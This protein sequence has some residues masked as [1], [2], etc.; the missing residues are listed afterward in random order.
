MLKENLVQTLEEAIRNHWYAPALADYGSAA[1]SYGQVAERILRLHGLFDRFGVGKGDKIALIG[2]NSV[3]WCLVYLAAVTCGA[4]IVPILPDFSGEDVQHIVNHS[5]AVLLFASEGV[6][7]KLDEGSMKKLDAILSLTDFSLIYAKRSSWMGYPE[8]AARNFADKYGRFLS[9]D[10]FRFPRVKNAETAAI[11]YTSGTTGFSKGVMLAHNSL[12]ANIRFARTHMPLRAGDRI[13]SFLPLAH[14]YGCAFEFLFP[15]CLG[16]DITLLGKTPSPKIILQAFSEIR[17]RLVL[18]V[19]LVIEKIYRSKIRSK[20]EK[21]PVRLLRK[22]PGIGGMIEKKVLRALN[23]AFGGNFHE[24]IIGGAPFNAEVAEFLEKIGFRFTVGYGMTEC[25]P[26]ISYTGSGKFRLHS[27]GQCVDTL[28]VRIDSPDPQRVIG[29]ILVK[30]ENVMQG[31][32]KNPKATR[33]VI[34]KAGWLHTGDL[35]IVDNDGFIFIRGRSKSM[36]L[37]PS[38]E[39]V[40]PEEIEAR[41][42]NMACVQESLVVER[43]GQLV[44]LVYPDPE[45]VDAHGMDEA[46]LKDLMEKNRRALNAALPSAWAI[47]RIEMFPEEFEKTPTRKIKRFIYS[48]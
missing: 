32:Y 33:E 7:E 6:S 37:G 9:P 34:D 22:V 21:T 10:N 16:C 1:C 48:V 24:I 30:G 47:A 40:Y 27:V 26:L 31:Y 42:N 29:E 44:A 4:V 13:V 17:P 18:S 38:G 15:F 12:I 14:A 41:L 45:A 23:S 43:S 5:D 20:I 35:G 36:L 39:N 25:G 2:K 19:P 11:V 8:K 46:G 28:E 3:N